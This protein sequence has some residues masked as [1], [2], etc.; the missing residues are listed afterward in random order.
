MGSWK[1]Q[2]YRV[3]FVFFLPFPDSASKE[4]DLNFENQCSQVAY[5]SNKKFGTQKCLGFRHFQIFE[6]FSYVKV[7][8]T[9][10]IKRE[11]QKSKQIHF[12]SHA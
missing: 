4:I 6:I 7:W 8:Y 12:I 11:I 1:H 10:Q 2:P 9:T 3:P 5:L